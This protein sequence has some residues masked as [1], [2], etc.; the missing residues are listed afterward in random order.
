MGTTEHTCIHSHQGVIHAVPESFLSQTHT[1]IAVT[2][3]TGRLPVWLL[4]NRQ[5]RN[6]SSRLI[7][8]CTRNLTTSRCPSNRMA[9]HFYCASR[10]RVGWLEVICNEKRSYS[11]FVYTII[12]WHFQQ[13]IKSTSTNDHSNV[14]RVRQ[15][16]KSFE[17]LL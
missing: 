5:A 2:T 8:C 6:Q 11:S 16:L 15:F 3:A 14:F 12:L 1:I 4:G 13:I 7:G 17:V 9:R 10:K